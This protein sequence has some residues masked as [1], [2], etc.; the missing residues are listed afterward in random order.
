MGVWLLTTAGAVFVMIV[1]G[2]VTRLTRSG[3]SIVEWRPEGEALPRSD[4]EWEVAFAKYQRFP[5]YK[6]VNSGMTLEEFKP[7]YWMEWGHRQWGRAIGLIFAGPLVYWVASK[8]LPPGMGPRLGGLLLLGGAQGGVGWWMV[9]SGLEAERFVDEWTVPRVS[10]Y[11]LAT[12]VREGDW[13]VR[14]R[15]EER[16]QNIVGRGDF[17]Q[18]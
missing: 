6:K 11:R 1:L 17:I 9:K 7:I 8:R 14:G 10:P 15:G 18:L 13:G 12:H 5:E 16:R 2:G 3:L 4:A